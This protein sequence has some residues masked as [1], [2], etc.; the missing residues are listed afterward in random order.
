MSEQFLSLSEYTVIAEKIVNNW[1]KRHGKLNLTD[2]LIANVVRYMAIADKKYTAE[3]ANGKSRE[4]WRQQRAIYAIR[5]YLYEQKN[6]KTI[7]FTD[8][9]TNF[10]NYDSKNCYEG[11]NSY[12]FL[13]S[14]MKVDPKNM[15]EDEINIAGDNHTK[16]DFLIKNSGL[17]KKE[18]IIINLLKEGISAHNVA[19]K[20]NRSVKL[21]YLLRNNAIIKMRRICRGGIIK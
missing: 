16:L 17:T 19:K 15:F 7:C 14:L 10:I 11:I 6:K 4:S 20:I 3:L 5:Q 18:S 2:D 12:G 13:E 8:L 1:R 9:T 21:V